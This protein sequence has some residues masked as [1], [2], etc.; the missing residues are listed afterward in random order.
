MITGFFHAGVTVSDME[1]SLRFYRDGL[2][3][4]VT[5][6]YMT[7]GPSAQR[8]WN[9]PVGPVEVAFLR[10]PGSDVVVELFEF[11]EIERHNASARPPDP[12]AGHF[13][14]YTDDADGL[15]AKLT[16]MGFSSRSGAIVE[17]DGGPHAG[18]KVA[19]M[20]DPDGYHVEIYQRA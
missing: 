14:L 11:T 6:Q 1:A 3:L 7:G 19:Y 17:M 20:I 8:V 13:C 9:L 18:T 10:V 4:E 5:K 15:H 2:G 12:G 16:G